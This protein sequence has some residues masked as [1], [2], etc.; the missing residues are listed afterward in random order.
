MNLVIDI[1]NTCVKLVA[2]DGMTPIE[3]VRMEHGETGPLSQM[4]RRYAFHRGIYSSVVSLDEKMH[5]FIS[6][7]DFPML[8]FQPDRT[9]IPIR[10]KYLTPGTL[11]GDRLAAAIGAYGEYPG[12]NIL[13]VDVGTCITYDFVSS[14]G[15][16]MGGNI[17]PGPTIRLK[18]L[19]QYTDSLP[20]VVRKGDVLFHGNST[21]TAVRSGVMLGVKY[22]VEGYVSECFRR[23]PDLKVFLTGGVQIDLQLPENIQ[24]IKDGYIVPKGLNRVLIYNNEKLSKQ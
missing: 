11:G 9:P 16:Y 12:H 3:E 19:H 10:N 17:S 1:G 22:E 8:S 21:E 18:A 13:V 14:G 20:L 6:A 23:V 7:L 24:I 15:D 4:C 5:G 2:F